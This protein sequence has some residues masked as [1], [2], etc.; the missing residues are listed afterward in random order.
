MGGSDPDDLVVELRKEAVRCDERRLLVV[1]GDEA[2]TGTVVEQMLHSVNVP[3]TETVHVGG[4]DRF[5]CERVDPNHVGELLGLTRSIVILDCHRQC[6]PNTLGAAIG[7]VDGGGLLILRTPSLETW[8]SKPD[9]FDRSM[10]VEPYSIDDVSNRFK[11]RLVDTLRS[12]P[13]IAIVSVGDDIV[14]ERR[15]L[16]GAPT[17]KRK[18][19]SIIPASNEFPERAYELCVTADQCHAL[20]TLESLLDSKS[21]VVIESDRG[22]GKSAALGIAAACLAVR[23]EHV[24]LTAPS[25]SNAATAFEMADY[26]VTLIGEQLPPTDAGTI[27]TTGG[28]R[29]RFVPARKVK[30]ELGGADIILVDEAAGIPVKTLRSFLANDRVGFATTVHGYEGAGRGFSVRFRD[31]LEESDLELTTYRLSEP[32][33]Y[34]PGD[35]LEIW[36]FR[37]LLLDARP[38]VSAIITDARPESVTYRSIEQA[39]IAE[40]GRLLREI[41]GLLVL[42]HYR[43]TP[44]DVARLLDAPNLHIRVLLHENHVVSVAL[45]AEEGG[46]SDEIA[47]TTYTGTAIRGHMIPEL[48]L[49]QLQDPEAGTPKGIR[50]VRIAT[51]QDRRSVGLGSTLV[52]S[53]LA[54]FGGDVDWVGVGFG[55][56]PALISFWSSQWFETV[57]LSITR[58]DRSGEHSAIMIRPTSPSGRALVERH[59]RWGLDRL[60]GTVTDVHRRVDPGIVDAVL[61]AIRRPVHIELDDRDWAMLQAASE[62]R[63]TYQLHP[64][65][66]RSLVLKHFVDPVANVELEPQQRAVL[67][68]KILQGRSW[69]TVADSMGYI[70]IRMCMRDLGRGLDTLV[71]AYVE[72]ID[73]EDKT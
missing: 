8:P 40:D 35:P 69:M 49:D 1:A 27:R 39:D 54:E 67:V 26:V 56:T 48:L 23:G 34:A 72:E 3:I 7:V 58:S 60:Q 51:H 62:G 61:G 68:A 2:D 19:S 59:A 4:E 18:P 9:E 6:R 30:P 22:R 57:H 65:P 37:A 45:V 15:G 12:H 47:L 14:I 32:I 36:S 10:V 28:G 16:T 5:R 31:D 43:T 24:L 38:P 29:I 66:A 46:L 25:Y 13:G 20:A 52:G 63:G 73:R 55:V 44:D 71:D 42:A 21:A 33:R 11:S 64:T 41:V 50:I 17:R 70:S 53:I